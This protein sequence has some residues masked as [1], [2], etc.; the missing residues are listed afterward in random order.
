MQIIQFFLYIYCR[1]NLLVNTKDGTMLL[2]KCILAW[3]AS[4]CLLMLMPLSVPGQASGEKPA[5]LDPGKPLD[6][7]IEDLLSRM[8][9][10]EK[11]GQLNMPCVYVNELGKDIPAKMEGCRKFTEGTYV[12][13]LGPGGGFFTL[14][15]TILHE[16][17]RQQAEFLNE[18]QRIATEKTR[19]KIPLLITEEGTHGLMCPGGTIFPEGLALGSTWNMDLLK[20]IYSVVAR[21]AGATGVHQVFTLVIE[22]NRDPRL[23]RNQEGFSEDPYLC[24]RIAE[25]IVTG[26]QGD[27]VSA[28]DKVVAGLCHYPGQSQPVSGLERGAIEFTEKLFR[29]SFLPPWE[30][31]IRK[32]GALGVMATYPAVLDVPVH[33]SSK[34]LTSILREELDFDGLV[35]SEGGGIS[36]LLYEGLASTEQDAG[37]LAIEAGVD[38]GISYEDSYMLAMIENVREGRV[39]MEYIDRAVRRILKQKYRLGLFEN[40]FVDADNAVRVVHSKEHQEL[41]L[42]AAREGIV[43]LKNEN[44]LL[45]LD[46]NIKS[47]A[48]IGPNADHVM[49]QLGDYV[50]WTV[51]QDVVTIL[52]GIKSKVS[53]RTKVVY[54]KG[55]DVIGDGT[56]EISKARKAAKKAD[57]AI[58][59][60]GENE[61][62]TEGGK[63]TD[64]EGR[65]VASLDLTGRQ[66]ELVRAVYETGTPTIVVLVNGRPLSIR[67][68]AE[69]VPAI[70]EPWLCGEQGGNAVADVLFG[71]YNPSGRLSITIPRHSGQLP[72]FYN[73]KKSK[74]YWM[75]NGWSKP[76]ADMSSEPLFYFGDGLSYTTYEY[77]NL[78]ITP[79][80]T[81]PAGEIQVSADIK[82]TGNH[83][84]AETVQLYINDVIATVSTPRMELKGFTKVALEP[85]ETKRVDFALTPEHL[86]LINRHL[87]RVVE[88]GTFEVMVG[89]SSNDIRLKGNI[90]IKD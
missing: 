20:D 26:V 25:S 81:G 46:K 35:M 57:V 36:T 55:C 76:Y 68:T 23:G 88:Q 4:A 58:V 73:Y 77:S 59:V 14:T 45:P 65:D 48:V 40:P 6:V 56:D 33:D 64:G 8:T 53:P 87:E 31:G 78:R 19:L 5:Y 12:K 9:L 13:G 32:C 75:Y 86:S 54:V 67:W 17:T 79:P 60:V 85:G 70:L 24:S 11:I 3:C 51:L 50:A 27:D 90:V 21:E 10:E 16:G 7:R 44:N 71:D 74:A 37:K 52:E 41:A 30:A 83:Q 69:H 62:Q 39:S 38:V 84:G 47:I 49:N 42:R 61:W 43:L 28:P 63:G 34:I 29:E 80:Q 1:T 2:K 89:H 22:P 82:N 72:V 15:N 66:E 18:L